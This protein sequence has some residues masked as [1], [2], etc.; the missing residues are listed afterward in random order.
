MLKIP[1]TPR[2]NLVS[3]SLIKFC[4]KYFFLF[5]INVYPKL[6]V[7]VVAEISGYVGNL[8]VTEELRDEEVQ[9][10]LR[11]TGVTEKN[12]N[13]NSWIHNSSRSWFWLR[14][15]WIMHLKQ[16]AKIFQ[17]MP[18]FILFGNFWATIFDQLA[19]YRK[20]LMS[21]LCQF[22]IQ[23]WLKCFLIIHENYVTCARRIDSRVVDN[24][25]VYSIIMQ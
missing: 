17:K 16:S 22:A 10:G 8:L 5:A 3:K 20:F 19:I 23:Y 15:N 6:T 18:L 14:T 21:F 7:G 1:K 24:L 11:G 4:W 2:E 13:C 25:S 9:V 12:Q